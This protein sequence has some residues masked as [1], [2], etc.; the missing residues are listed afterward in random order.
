MTKVLYPGSFDP[1]HNG[2][3]GI[4]T[5]ASN[6]FDEVVI[7]AMYNPQKPAPLFDGPE[8]VEM[9]SEA[10]EHLGNVSVMSFYA[11]VVQLAADMEADLIV[12]GLRGVDDFESEMQMAQMN[13]A[14]TGIETV[15]FPATS[16]DSYIASKYIRDIARFGGEVSHMMPEPVARR[17]AEKL[18]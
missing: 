16:A 4:I 8:R 2:H 13:K 9:I 17:L 1:L 14:V 10:V 11:L 6:L 7:A 3:M 15:F 5:T 12:K 18:S